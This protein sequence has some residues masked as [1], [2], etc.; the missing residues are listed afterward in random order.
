MPWMRW[1]V[2]LLMVSLIG[3]TNGCGNK[4][5]RASAT[6][7]ETTSETP[8]GVYWEGQSQGSATEGAAVVT[9][10]RRSQN[11][12]AQVK[13]GDTYASIVARF[14][15][16]SHQSIIY[17]WPT[18]SG[19]FYVGFD[20]QMNANYFST[21]EQA[22]PE[23]AQEIAGLVAQHV[24]YTSIA[25]HLGGDPQVASGG[26]TWKSQDGHTVDVH[27]AGEKVGIVSYQSGTP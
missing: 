10:K 17:V 23:R 11:P 26:A 2:L 24:S 18:I 6:A 20:D 13:V 8:N 22:L 21:N 3:L 7:S 15:K 9:R 19:S 16:P 12:F 1:S 4:S 25:A 5:R 14:G 27:F